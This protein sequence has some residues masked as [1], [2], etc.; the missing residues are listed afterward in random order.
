MVKDRPRIALIHATPIAMRPIQA[1]FESGWPEAETVNI[2]DDSLAPDRSKA[3]KLTG[4]FFDRF[5]AL[6]SYAKSIGSDAVLFTCSAFGEAIEWAAADYEIPVLK[7]NEAMF[8]VAIRKGG[9]IA[10]LYTFAPSRDGME[11]EFRDEA[12]RINPAASITSFMVPG[13]IEAVRSGDVDTHNHLIAQEAAKLSGFDAIVLAHFSTSQALAA[14]QRVT[15]IPV[16]TSPD[17]AVA[18]LRALVGPDKRA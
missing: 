17:A 6:T 13:A 1:A 5:K 9:R 12:E 14:V 3:S 15:R 8:E 7:P 4:A 10:M 18:K 2:L 11:Q 16:L